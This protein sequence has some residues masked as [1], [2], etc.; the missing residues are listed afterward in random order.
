LVGVEFCWLERAAREA[1]RSRNAPPG[2]YLSDLEHV[3]LLAS[4]PRRPGRTGHVELL[5]LLGDI[6]QDRPQSFVLDDGG[7]VD[8]RALVESAV[9]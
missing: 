1:F 2:R 7:L 9:G 8:L 6:G 5:L 4:S 3:V